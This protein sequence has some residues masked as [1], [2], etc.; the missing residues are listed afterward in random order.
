[1]RAPCPPAHPA[2]AAEIARRGI[3]IANLSHLVGVHAGHLGR[4]IRGAATLSPTLE[5]RIAD[6]LGVPAG[7]LFGGDA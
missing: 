4:V 5:T 6:A 7:D 1:M 3:T 2:L